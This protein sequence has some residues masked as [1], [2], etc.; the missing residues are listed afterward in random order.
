MGQDEYVNWRCRSKCGKLDPKFFDKLFFPSSGRVSNKAKSYCNDCPVMQECLQ[1]AL[2]TEVDGIRA[3][4]TLAE[5]RLMARWHSGVSSGRRVI[6]TNV[7][8]S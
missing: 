8:F 5:R 6:R 2:E 3:G 1:D 4:T 7:V